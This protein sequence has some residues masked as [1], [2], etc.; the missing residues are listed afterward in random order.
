MIVFLSDHGDFVGEYG[1]LRKGPELP[2]PL[3]RIPLVFAG[4]GIRA[5]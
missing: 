2:E 3:V 4:P 5:A 1:L